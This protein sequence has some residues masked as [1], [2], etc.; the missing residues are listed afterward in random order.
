MY[1]GDLLVAIAGRLAVSSGLR[2]PLQVIGQPWCLVVVVD[3]IVVV[4]Q[5]L[6]DLLS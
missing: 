4:D 6:L 2:C 1:A 3:C 5:W